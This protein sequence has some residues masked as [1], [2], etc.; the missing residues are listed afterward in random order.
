[1]PCQVCGGI[2]TSSESRHLPDS[3]SCACALQF[4]PPT[5]ECSNLG[6]STTKE[7]DVDD[8]MKA[9]HNTF[10]T[11]ISVSRKPSKIPKRVGMYF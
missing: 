1:M 6:T 2:S 9:N 10:K 4:L 8:Y 11:L 7:H 5:V 3:I